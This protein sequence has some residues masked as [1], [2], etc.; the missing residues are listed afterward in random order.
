MSAGRLTLVSLPRKIKQ[1]ARERE[2][3]RDPEATGN[4]TGRGGGGGRRRSA[5]A[6]ASKGAGAA[7]PSSSLAGGGAFNP[8]D[9]ARD[10][11][12]LRLSRDQV[13]YCS[14]ALAFFRKKL[15]NRSKIAQ[16]FDK[17]QVALR[18]YDSFILLILLSLPK[19]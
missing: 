1:S 15:Q 16:E 7:S 11:P 10:P 6:A 2:S 3:K 9:L 12:P 5:M 19:F 17:L 14:E 4:S 18:T 13:K 8:H